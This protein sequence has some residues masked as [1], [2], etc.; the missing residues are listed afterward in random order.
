MYLL[1]VKMCTTCATGADGVPLMGNIKVWLLKH[2]P[3]NELIILLC[4]LYVPILTHTPTP[5]MLWLHASFKIS[6][7][8]NPLL[9]NTLTI[10][11][12]LQKATQTL[13]T[14]GNLVMRTHCPESNQQF[15]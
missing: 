4:F 14:R 5:G 1:N 6:Q 12:V 7:E 8:K 10:A 11:Q 2:I 15:V 3:L 13:R 9:C